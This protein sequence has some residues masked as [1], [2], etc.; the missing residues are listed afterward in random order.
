V[1]YHHIHSK[2]V[3]ETSRILPRFN[4]QYGE[5]TLSHAASMMGTVG[6]LNAVKKFKTQLSAGTIKQFRRKDLGN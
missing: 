2:R 4:A 6:F 5:E 3:S 1:L